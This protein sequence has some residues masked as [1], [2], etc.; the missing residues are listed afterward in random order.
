MILI[1]EYK[2]AKKYSFPDQLKTDPKEKQKEDYCKRYCQSIYHTHIR[3]KASVPYEWWTSAQILRDYGSGKQ[4]EFYYIEQLEGENNRATTVGKVVNALSS[5]GPKVSRKGYKNLNTKIISVAQNLKNVVHGIF[6]NYEEDV[7]VNAIDPISGE[8]E[9]N[10]KWKAYVEAKFN[11]VFKQAEEKAG[12]RVPSETIFPDDVSM[13]ELDQYKALGGFKANWAIAM[14]EVL[15]FTFLAS[16]WDRTMKRKYIDDILDLN[17]IAGR[18][19]YDDEDMK[20]K[21]EYVDPAFFVMQYSQEKDFSDAEYGAYYK[22]EKIGALAQKGFTP[23][24]LMPAAKRYQEKFGNPTKS[25]WSKYDVPNSDGTY[26]WYDYRVPVM[27]CSWIDTD[28]SKTLK[29]STKYNKTTYLDLGFEEAPKPLSLRKQKAGYQQDVVNTNRKYTYQASWIVGTE[30]TYDYGKMINQPRDSKRKATLP[31]KAF[32]NVTTNNYVQF[33]SIIESIIPFLD[34]LQLAWLRLQDTLAKALDDGYAINLRLLN[35]LN[36]GGDRIKDHE[37]FEMFKKTSVL[38]YMDVSAPGQAYKGG[39][40]MPL[41][42]IP[43]GLGSR[44]EEARQVMMMNIEF[45][46]QFTGISR[47]VLGGFPSSRETATATRLAQEGTRAALQPFLNGIFDLKKRLADYTTKAIPIMLRNQSGMEKVYARIIGEQDAAFLKRVDR[48]GIEFGLSLESRP[49]FEDKERLI[50]YIEAAM[51]PDRSASAQLDFSQGMKLINMIQSG[52][53]VK[54][55]QMTAD[56]MI[57]KEQKRQQML[58]ERNQM[59]QN[60]AILAAKREDTNATMAEKR[61]DVEGN[62]AIENQKHVNEMELKKYEANLEYKQSLR[63]EIAHDKEM[64]KLREGKVRSEAEKSEKP[65]EE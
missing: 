57:K 35:G 41:H 12:I 10:S 19:Y 22:L 52:A 1:E 20:W 11:E 55:I 53:N 37:A 17:F 16:D 60:Q 8:I 62:M 24:Q 13:D 49:N 26:P 39:D 45:I 40:V 15:K 58:A 5:T 51:Q 18:C 65:K 3:N 63:E 7:F 25:E 34:Q 2:D 4:D 61:M 50:K 54:Q 44:L 42:R 21:M 32:R 59:M 29:Y 33:G 27:H 46:E 23:E 38:P 36:I 9:E 64:E 14:E 56:F 30:L 47:T 28:V 43:G 31:F 6:G 48:E